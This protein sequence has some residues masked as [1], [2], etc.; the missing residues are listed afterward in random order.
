MAGTYDWQASFAAGVLG[1]G[2][3]GRV[4]LAKYQVGLKVGYNIFIHAHG[5]F[6]NRPGT[7][8]VAFARDDLEPQRLIP[9]ER[10]E[11]TSYAL[12]F[13]DGFM[14]V[15]QRGKLAETGGVVYELAQPYT[16]EQVFALN[17]VQSIDVMYLAH[18]LHP[19]KK[20]MHL[21]ATSWSIA[22]ITTAP[23]VPTP[24]APTVVPLNT[25]DSKVYQY[26]ISAVVGGIEGL[27]GPIGQVT[28][29]RD[30]AKQGEQNTLTWS[31]LGTAPDEYRVYK[32][33]GGIWGYIGFTDGA[34]TTFL[35]DNIDPD[36][37]T[38]I[39]QTTTLFNGAGNY[40]S[41]VALTQQRLIWAASLNKP[42]TIWASVIG[43]YEN[44]SRA[45]ILKADDRIEIDIS[46]EKLNRVTG[47]VG[48]QE[49]VALTGSGEY[50]IGASNGTLSATDP[51]QV[52]YGASGSSGIRPL[53][54]G[55]SILYVDRSGRQV[56][57]L[58]YSF[59]SDG[60]AGND[61]SVFINHFLNGRRI[62]DWAYCHS[63]FGIVW[64]ARDDG[65]VLSLTYKREQEVWAWTEHFFGG[66]VESLCAL[67]EDGYDALYLSVIRVLGGVQRRTI[68][69]L[70]NRVITSGVMDACFLD[71]A[72]SY[73]GPLTN[74]ITG[75]D[76]LEGMTINVLADGDVFEG[77][78]VEGGAVTLPIRFTQAHAGLPYV[79]EGETL[80]LYVELQGTGA[81]RGL[82]VKAVETFFQL[83]N[84]RGI[85]V[86]AGGVDGWTEMVQTEFDLSDSIPLYTGLWRFDQHVDFSDRATI[87]VRQR[88]PLPMTVLGISP[89]WVIGRG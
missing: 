30:L 74:T 78:V 34:T 40:P 57:D 32:M 37:S 25:G 3:H 1:P 79:S 47:L 28:D 21:A 11:S 26:R 64:V 43:D 35:D 66:M 59:E 51:R 89:K 22:N 63:P 56:R 18:A 24:G 60:Y 23:D 2:L 71:A 36:T 15:V 82:P 4:D 50:G 81:T 20:L 49:L 27:P 46:G 12:A 45:A 55:D 68:E 73:Q 61:L 8:F 44:Y 31:A 69:R 67:H 76:H 33:R 41:V 10:D 38:S 72:V 29:A 48:M 80:P 9:F 65:Q 5:G 62:R 84:T 16:G 54:V 19:P 58:R 87:R 70:C 77:R 52:R 53:L 39:R 88:Y 6:S 17:Y 13:N 14:R 75:L 86:S 85:E 7:R 83:E 42:E